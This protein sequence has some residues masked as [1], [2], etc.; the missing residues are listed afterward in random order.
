MEPEINIVIPVNHF[1]RGKPFY[2]IFVSY[3]IQIIG[4]KELAARG[5]IGPP[6]PNVE[7]IVRK[8][9]N[10]GAIGE[11]AQREIEIEEASKQLSKLL[12][13]LQLRSE[14]QNNHIVVEIDDIAKDIAA[15]ADY[16]SSYLLLAAGHLLILAYEL[17]KTYSDKGPLWEFL[18]HCRNAAAH[19]GKFSFK[20]SEPRRPAIWG[21]FQ[22]ESTLEGTPLFKENVRDSGLFSIG[23]P[24]RLLWD[25]EQA[26]P[27]MKS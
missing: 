12:G 25:I 3:L 4:F 1:D 24:I 23:D 20:S 7:E 11:A 18:R 22:I 10:S 5:V 8:I 15:N 21:H 17:C 2:P 26:Y 14:F 27:N 16:L 19:G 9:D 13:P 6:Y